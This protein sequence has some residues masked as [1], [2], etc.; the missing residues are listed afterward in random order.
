MRRSKNEGSSTKKT[1]KRPKGSVMKKPKVCEK[2]STQPWWK[3]PGG[4]THEPAWADNIVLALSQIFAKLRGLLQINLWIDCAGHATE[5]DAGRKLAE[6]LHNR[7]G[8]H[9]NFNLYMA[10][11]KEIHCKELICSQYEPKHFSDNITFRDYK[12]RTFHCSICGHYEMMPTQGID[13]YGCCFP[14]GPWSPRG[15]KRGFKDPA[16]AV[17]DH[18]VETIKVIRPVFYYFENVLNLADSKTTDEVD[19]EDVAMTDLKVIERYTK[20]KLV[21]Y[22][23]VVIQGLTPTQ[24]GFPVHKRRMSIAGSDL[25]HVLA[26]TLARMYGQLLQWPVQVRLLLT[27][28]PDECFDF[29]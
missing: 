22:D 2:A 23:S 15:L 18:A 25:A 6:A 9:V 8:V 17:L 4:G 26:G 27:P 10:C 21:D 16:S 3:M 11:D 13:I 1:M 14:C 24:A 19:E 28:L 5:M 12:E 7:L 29:A 20:E